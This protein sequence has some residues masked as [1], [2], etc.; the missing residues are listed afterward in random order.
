M[1]RVICYFWDY[2]FCV[3]KKTFL[4]SLGIPG[5]PS[6]SFLGSLGIPRA[7]GNPFLESLFGVPRVT[8]NANAGNM[9]KEYSTTSSYG[10]G[11]IGVF[12]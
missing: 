6:D 8:L 1:L 4:E 10:L 11:L 7:P 5:A 12:L 3:G 9:L 2:F